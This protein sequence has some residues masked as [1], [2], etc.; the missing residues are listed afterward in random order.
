MW[1]IRWSYGYNKAKDRVD[2]EAKRQNKKPE[3]V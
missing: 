2:G 1:D 3:E